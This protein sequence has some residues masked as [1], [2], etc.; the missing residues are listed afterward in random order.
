MLHYFT[1]L[2]LC[3]V[4]SAEKTQGHLGLQSETLFSKLKHKENKIAFIK[5]TYK[6][7]ICN[8]YKI[9]NIIYKNMLYIKIYMYI[10]I[11]EH[12]RQFYICLDLQVPDDFSKLL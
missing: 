2:S 5:L 7:L 11:Q 12:C 9:Y 10:G 4:L 8:I 6:T 3:L 1:F